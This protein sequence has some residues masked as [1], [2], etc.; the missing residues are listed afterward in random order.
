MSKLC[1]TDG[2]CGKVGIVT[3]VCE[4]ECVTKLWGTTKRFAPTLPL[5]QVVR[6]AQASA[7]KPGLF[8]DGV[9]DVN[10]LAPFAQTFG[11]AAWYDGFMFDR[12]VSLAYSRKL[13]LISGLLLLCNICIYYIYIYILYLDTY[14]HTYIYMNFF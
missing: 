7:E 6:L 3:G 10:L 1:V 14:I 9:P 5:P 13:S 2:V 12:R 8:P 4:T 11:E